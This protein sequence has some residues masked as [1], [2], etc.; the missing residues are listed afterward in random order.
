MSKNSKARNKREIVVICSDWRILF[1]KGLKHFIDRDF[2][3]AKKY[4]QRAS[5]LN[6]MNR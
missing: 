3:K 6:Q 1:Y 2:H 4:L 5:S